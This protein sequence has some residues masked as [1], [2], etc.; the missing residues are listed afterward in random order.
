M[1]VY[2]GENKLEDSF[3]IEFIKNPKR[4]GFKSFER[5]EIYKNAKTIS[6][7]RD[8]NPEFFKLDLKYDLQK[9]FCKL[10]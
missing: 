7:L 8:K 3:K 6:E 2:I 4:R 1:S 5:Y 9:N 10:I